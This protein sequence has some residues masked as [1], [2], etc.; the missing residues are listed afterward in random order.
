MWWARL[1]Y[2]VAWSSNVDYILS[3]LYYSLLATI[4]W[5]LFLG[6]PEIVSLLKYFGPW[7]WDHRMTNKF[8]HTLPFC[9]N[10]VDVITIGN[11]QAVICAYTKSCI[12]SRVRLGIARFRFCN[13]VFRGAWSVSTCLSRKELLS[14][15]FNVGI[16]RRLETV[17]CGLQPFFCLPHWLQIPVD[18][19]HFWMNSFKAFFRDSAVHAMLLD[20]VNHVRSNMVKLWKD[21]LNRI[22]LSVGQVDKA[23]CLLQFN[24]AGCVEH[25]LTFQ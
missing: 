19:I 6:I 3:I 4:L 10:E 11:F 24:D 15:A 23:N 9:V 22:T 2:D 8:I 16:Q 18:L 12:F 21:L 17:W 14:E 25:F 1:C 13:V 5:S 7:I 20:E